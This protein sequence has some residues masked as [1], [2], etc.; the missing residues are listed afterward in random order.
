MNTQL[1][2]DNLRLP[3][4][5]PA[6]VASLL[7]SIEQICPRSPPIPFQSK[8]LPAL[9]RNVWF[10]LKRPSERSGTLC[11]W[12]QKQCCVYISGDYHKNGPR[13]ALL[14]L[15]ID[16]QFYDTGLTIMT[17]TLSASTRMLW[18]EDMLVW[19]GRRQLEDATFT[20]RW[21][22]AKQWLDHYCMCDSRLIGGLELEMAQWVPLADVKASGVWE[23]QSDEARR[24]RLL[25]IA[26]AKRD[27]PVVKEA[28]VTVSAVPAGNATPVAIATR[29]PA[30]GPDQWDLASTDG[31]SLGRALIRTIA[32]SDMLRSA[33][34]T[35]R[36][37]VKWNSVFGKWEVL[38]LTT[39]G[40]STSEYFA[41]HQVE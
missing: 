36:I 2:G 13:V 14:R 8:H 29:L 20:A 32:I 31:K 19:K 7:A 35:T 37:E 17:A 28:E 5:S 34:A 40:A 22:L 41:L 26:S 23:L 33:H 18:I 24:R 25:W 16:P 1:W 27:V 21:L 15:R 30:V 10:A 11:I 6:D 39:R 4:F 12:P 38:N 3:C 9:K